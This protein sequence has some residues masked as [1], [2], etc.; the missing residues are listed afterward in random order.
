MVLQDSATL[1]SKILYTREMIK[2]AADQSHLKSSVWGNCKCYLAVSKTILKL[3]LFCNQ[4]IISF[5]PINI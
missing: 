1:C 3:N 2:V 4:R 5:I